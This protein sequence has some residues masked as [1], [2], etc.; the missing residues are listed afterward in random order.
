[1]LSKSGVDGTTNFLV[2][3]APNAVQEILIVSDVADTQQAPCRGVDHEDAV[4]AIDNDYG[5]VCI[6]QQRFVY[7]TQLRGLYVSLVQI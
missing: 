2:G 4:Q 3:Q 7:T 5:R 6:A 1:M